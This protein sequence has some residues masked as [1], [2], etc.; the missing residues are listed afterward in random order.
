MGGMKETKECKIPTDPK[1][2]KKR[3]SEG[4]TNMKIE[5]GKSW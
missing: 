3:K 2:A 1:E 5:K 4:N